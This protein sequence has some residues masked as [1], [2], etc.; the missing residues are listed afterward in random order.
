MLKKYKLPKLFYQKISRPAAETFPENIICQKNHRVHGRTR[1][2]PPPRRP[3]GPALKG[4]TFL[5]PTFLLL[6]C[7]RKVGAS[8]GP[9]LQKG[10]GQSARKKTHGA[11]APKL[12]AR[13]TCPERARKVPP[14]HPTPSL[15]EK[16][17]GKGC[18]WFESVRPEAPRSSLSNRHQGLRQRSGR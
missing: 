2:L 3:R 10:L 14:L 5:L 16:I 4:R 12:G 7:K 6:R 17:H 15:P 1:T 18:K 9:P 8:Q 11:L 13:G